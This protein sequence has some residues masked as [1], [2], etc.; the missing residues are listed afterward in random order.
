MKRAISLAIMAGVVGML[1]GCGGSNVNRLK[2]SIKKAIDKHHG[3]QPMTLQAKTLEEV[4]EVMRM[5]GRGDLA[6]GPPQNL[7][8][9]V[10]WWYRISTQIADDYTCEVTTTDS[11]VAKVEL[12]A[13]VACTTLFPTKEAADKADLWKPIDRAYTMVFLYQDK[14][15]KL[16]ENDSTKEPSQLNNL[17]GK[18]V[19]ALFPRATAIP[20]QTVV[21]QPTAQISPNPFNKDLFAKVHRV[22]LAFDERRSA[23]EL[24]IE[25][26]IIESAIKTQEERNVY[27][28]FKLAQR[29]QGAIWLIQQTHELGV[30]GVKVWNEYADVQPKI[31][32][33]YN[34]GDKRGENF[35]IAMM[36]TKGFVMCANGEPEFDKAAAIMLHFNFP[37]TRG[38]FYSWIPYES[39]LRFLRTVNEVCISKAGKAINNNGIIPPE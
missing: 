13:Q 37:V 15:W 11:S 29:A 39:S 24:I 6:S 12:K 31:E 18:L 25:L 5:I 2:A 20:Q 23:R 16:S 34:N 38:K 8:P 27:E 30:A 36:T 1:V 21:T 28:T 22:A 9:F 7:Q 33:L 3:S 10:N 32:A 17:D 26:Q 35:E 14:D 19:S 4:Q